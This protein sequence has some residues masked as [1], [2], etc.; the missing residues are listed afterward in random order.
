MIVRLA[1]LLAT[2]LRIWLIK[3]GQRCSECGG[4]FDSP[5]CTVGPDRRPAHTVY[6][7]VQKGNP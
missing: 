3:T 2:G 4:R 6:G 5:G 1:H 7:G